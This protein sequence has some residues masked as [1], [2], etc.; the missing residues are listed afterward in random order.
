MVVQPSKF[1]YDSR[2]SKKYLQ[3]KIPINTKAFTMCSPSL[4]YEF[5][6]ILGTM[7][8]ELTHNT[9]GSHSATFYKSMDELYEEVE[10]DQRN[11]II[12][13]SDGSSN[14]GPFIG[15]CNKVG[16]SGV[17]EKSK[18]CL[19]A[20]AALKRQRA[21]SGSSS[22]GSRMT[23]NGGYILGGKSLN[24]TSRAELRIRIIDAAQQRQRDNLSCPAESNSQQLRL[25]AADLDDMWECPVCSVMNTKNFSTCSFCFFDGDV[26][27]GMC[28]Q[29]SCECL[30]MRRERVDKKRLEDKRLIVQTTGTKAV[31]E[32]DDVVF[33]CEIKHS[34]VNK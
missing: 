20:E 30:L 28:I 31:E 17:G 6:H 12:G 8:H 24:K 14:F 29:S 15:S 2:M 23:E 22:D 9:V 16:G 27:C 18:S 1:D 26:M 13:S 21:M 25:S 19:A 7:I 5:D 11:G 32:D 33:V 4:F 10:R 3:I 34:Q